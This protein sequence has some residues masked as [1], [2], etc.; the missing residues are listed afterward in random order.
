MLWSDEGRFLA[1]VM[2]GSWRAAGSSERSRIGE[3]HLHL[4]VLGTGHHL[5]SGVVPEYY[6]Q[7]FLYAIRQQVLSIDR[8]CMCICSEIILG[9]FALA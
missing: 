1:E 9:H 5:E 8:K 7:V 4:L 2:R 3:D 6:Q